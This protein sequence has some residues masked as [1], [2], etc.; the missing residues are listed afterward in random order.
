M[1]SERMATERDKSLSRVRNAVDAICKD[2]WFSSLWTLQEAFLCPNACFI[3]RD[4]HLCQGLVDDTGPAT[5]KQLSTTGQRLRTIVRGFLQKFGDRFEVKWAKMCLEIEELISN[6]GFPALNSQNPMILYA[7][8]GKR[9]AKYDFDYVYGIQ[10]VFGFRLG[11][12]RPGSP[13]RNYS[14]FELQARMGAALIDKCPVQSQMH[15]FS[16]P[17][18]DGQGW[19]ISLSSRLPESPGWEDLRDLISQNISPSSTIRAEA[20]PGGG[21][22]GFFQGKTCSFADFHAATPFDDHSTEFGGQSDSS[23]MVGLDTIR[24]TKQEPPQ[25]RAWGKARDISRGKEQ[26]ELSTWLVAT[27]S[28]QEFIVLRLGEAAHDSLISKRHIG[29]LLLSTKRQI[30]SLKYW[31][32]IGFVIWN[33]SQG[34][35][36]ESWQNVCGFFG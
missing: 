33:D 10:Q 4:G 9:T 15:V 8:A 18:E 6:K 14:R 32:R 29:L 21:A 3:S 30:N 28:E 2:P 16:M 17:V 20:H 26:V 11:N 23:F 34:G 7:A 5:L 12:S 13:R 22:V 1:A 36:I 19:S 27:Y 25:Y 24:E 35:N 31:K